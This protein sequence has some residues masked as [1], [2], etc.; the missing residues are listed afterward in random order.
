MPLLQADRPIKIQERH[1]RYSH[2]SERPSSLRMVNAQPRSS[3]AAPPPQGQPHLVL[4][5]ADDLGWNDVSW[6]NPQVVTPHLQNLAQTGVILEQSYVQPIC[7]PTRSAL[8]TGRYPFT[9]GRQH[10]VL[11][12][13]EPTGL[14]LNAT[15]I[16]ES[17]KKVGYSTHA[18]GKWHLGFCNW[19]YTP[20]S[21]GFDTFYGY[22]TGAEDYFHHFR[23]QMGRKEMPNFVEY[24]SHKTKKGTRFGYDFRNN[25]TPD[26]SVD[27]TYS[28]YAFAS[29]VENLLSS[30]SPRDPMFLYLPFQ[31]VH[32]PLEVPENYTRP[33]RH[34]KHKDRRT[35][36][37]M[38]TAMDEAV[39]RVV[40]AL[41]SSGHYNNSVIV[42][43]TDNGGPTVS[44]G[45]NWPLRGNKST[46]WEGGTRGAAFVHSPLLQNPGTVSHK[47]IHVTDWYKTF[48]G[49][50]GGEAPKDTDGFDQWS[51]L[52]GLSESP[53]TRMIYNIDNT[54]TFSAG[55]RYGDYKLL[56]GNPGP[57]EWTPPPEDAQ[58]TN[59]TVNPAL[60][61]PTPNPTGNQPGVQDVVP[62][63]TYHTPLTDLNDNSLIEGAV[64]VAPEDNGIFVTINN[65]TTNDWNPRL[66]NNGPSLSEYNEEEEEREGKEEEEEKVVEKEEKEEEEK[67][68]E[69]GEKEEEEEMVVEEEDEEN[70]E[71]GKEKVVEEKEEKE[72][73][74]GVYATEKNEKKYE[75]ASDYLSAREF[76]DSL[77]DTEEIRL[78][79][80]KLD[81]N[82][83][84]NI[85][86][87]QPDVVK[88]LLAILLHQL[89]TRYVDAD[90]Q[91]NDPRANP[92]YWHNFWSPGWCEAK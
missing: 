75:G 35:K 33:Y 63:S 44:A 81:P 84:T 58:D 57:G 85:A 67:V 34:I 11:W 73:E 71:E 86:A 25:T 79:N 42:F 12:P 4:I 66:D 69:K 31:S 62:T 2:W 68:V 3:G 16:P 17:L 15:L 61:H 76:V 77:L 54:T 9:L 60:F 45:N 41:K 36:L 5:V 40:A 56:V 27:G 13:K 90:L 38:V 46:L 87:S 91:P 88:I 23:L 72:N 1:K 70:G 39:G 7:T 47:L 29:Y 65:S 28:T 8:L 43:T 64:D 20:T 37:G 92:K 50:A 83:R 51:A 78:F 26:L 32:S 24:P 30:R 10:G 49:L 74:D 53:R 55:I 14:T 82:E 89:D 18:V 19:S 22:Y 52:D 21:R 59:S 80:L 48:M 6:H